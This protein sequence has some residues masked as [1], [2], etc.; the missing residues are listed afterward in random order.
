MASERNFNLRD[1]TEYNENPMEKSCANMD[2]FADA[3]NRGTVF[4]DAI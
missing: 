4:H 3:T 1:W 2:K